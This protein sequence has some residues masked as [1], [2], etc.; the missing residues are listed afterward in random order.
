MWHLY[1]LLYYFCH[2]HHLAL[3]LPP[4]TFYSGGSQPLPGRGSGFYSVES[5]SDTRQRRWMEPVAFHFKWKRKKMNAELLHWDVM[6]SDSA[7]QR[8]V[9]RT[10]HT[11]S[12]SIDYHQH[13]SISLN[14]LIPR[15]T[16][17][18]TVTVKNVSKIISLL[19]SGDNKNCSHL[20]ALDH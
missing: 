18:K 5:S 15:V 17:A 6:H 14:S 10:L 20:T 2:F 8:A 19:Q 1:F 4:L 13:A 9:R 7:P 11:H 3:Y 12:L 16:K